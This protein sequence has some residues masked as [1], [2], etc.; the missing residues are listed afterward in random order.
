MKYFKFV[1]LPRRYVR[2]ESDPAIKSQDDK[3]ANFQ[4]SLEGNGQKVCINKVCI[5]VELADTPEKRQLGLMFRKRLDVNKGM[6]FIFEQEG[7]YSFWMKNMNFSLDLIWIGQDDK[8]VDVRCNILPCN[9][10]CESIIVE[11]PAKYVLEVNA[12]FVRKNSIKQGDKIKFL[13]ALEKKY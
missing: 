12:G 7:A 13:P 4:Q 8:V 3:K 10:L 9:D 5:G 1:I 2:A 6:L 11:K